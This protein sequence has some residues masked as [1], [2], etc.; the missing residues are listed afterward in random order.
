MAASDKKQTINASKNFARIGELIEELQISHGE[1]KKLVKSNKALDIIFEDHQTTLALLYI[2]IAVMFTLTLALFVLLLLSVFTTDIIAKDSVLGSVHYHISRFYVEVIDDGKLEEEH[3]IVPFFE[4]FQDI[5]RPPVDCSM[6]A[7]VSSV[8]MRLNLTSEEFK[9]RYAYSSRPLVV[10]DGMEGWTAQETFSFQYFQELY[11]T[12]SNAL[13]NVQED[14]QFFPYRT[15]FAKLGDVFNMTDD[16]AHLR[17][18]TKSKPW[19]IGWSNCDSTAA[20][21]LRKHYKKPYFLPQ[22]SESSKT[23]WIFM[24]SPDYGAPN[25]IDAVDLPSWQAQVKGH[26]IW[27]LTPPPECYLECGSRMEVTLHPGYI[28]IVDTN[29]WFHST[30]VIGDEMSIT[31][32]SEYD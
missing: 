12:G 4:P 26:K 16:E 20:N 29:S 7:N 21:S 15:H 10:M 19:Y 1:W 23:D 18:G 22:E 27:T 8:D 25:H 24:G 28:V 11:S 3:C 5:F 2:K 9:E 32:G 31:I 14:C 17:D 13:E 30:R 6:C